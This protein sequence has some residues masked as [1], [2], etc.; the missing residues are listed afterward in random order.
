MR[1]VADLDDDE[2][3]AVYREIEIA[4]ALAADAIAH[5]LEARREIA[6]YLEMLAK[7]EENFHIDETHIRFKLDLILKAAGLVE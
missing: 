2:A 1:K 7:W 3:M 6:E 5:P 4:D